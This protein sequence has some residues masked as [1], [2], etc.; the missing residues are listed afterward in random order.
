M[1]NH[2]KN[3][4]QYI[5]AIFAL[6]ALVH[7]ATAKEKNPGGE[8]EN[9]KVLDA[10][11]IQDTE[12][13]NGSFVRI[14]EKGAIAWKFQLN[15]P[16]W[17]SLNFRYR[18]PGGEKEEFI[19]RNGYRFAVG[20]PVS[21]T[22]N[23]FTTHTFL[24]KGENIIE[25][26]KSWSNIDIDRL[27][28]AAASL[29]PEITGKN[30]IFYKDT[31]R[32]LFVKINRFGH[33]LLSVTN[34]RKPVPFELTGFPYFE[35]AAWVK[36]P[37]KY[38]GGLEDKKYEIELNFQNNQKLLTNV[39]VKQKAEASELTLVALDIE[40]GTS[41]LLILPGGKTMLIDCAKD[42]VRDQI[43]IPFLERQ[44]IKKIDYMIMTHYHGD[45][46]SG[47]RGEKIRRMFGVEHF[48]DYKSFKTADTFVIE[49]V[50]V[51]VL[52]SFEDGD[53]EN[54]RSLSLRM[55]YKGFVYIHGGDTYADNQVK[56]L[57]RFPAGELRADVF[58][59]NHHFHGSSDV[60][61][62]RTLDPSLVLIQAQEAI[63]ARS[64][65]MEKFKK[66]TAGY[67]IENKHRFIEGLPNLEAGAV[68]IR[69]NGK[70]DWTYELYK[71]D[72]TQVI[73][74]LFK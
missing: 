61:F 16:G 27:E 51:K 46:D 66:E 50:S 40:H 31:P 54:R 25:L 26:Q 23:D 44:N 48:Y 17:Y 58:H 2:R 30:N 69:V 20:F 70:D 18:A 9:A 34:N 24:K 62:L 4:F 13:S 47:D 6:F 63:Y 38:F 57:G 28:I 10:A 22:W 41:M 67:L 64:T 35:D 21:D 55:E 32:D 39:E 74:A 1:K 3:I 37:A 14:G 65:Y 15:S 43:I 52:N 36:I 71:N 19:V 53:E 68:V 11:V 60:S 12:A 72:K 49:G 29:K 7:P 56:M 8:A 42:W 45:H 73:P 5:L 33:R 59:A